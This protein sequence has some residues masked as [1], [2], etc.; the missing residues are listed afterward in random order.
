M[1]PWLWYSEHLRIPTYFGMLMLGMALSTI[2]LRRESQRSGIHPKHVFD[3]ALLALPMVLLGARLAHAIL[4]EPAVYATQP[5]LIVRLDR[6]GF[7]FYGGLITGALVVWLRARR[8][9]I[10]PWALADIF[11]MAVPFGLIFGRLGCLGGGCC[12]GKPASWPLG[13]EVPW[14]ILM[15]R[16]NQVPDELMGIPL[17]PTPLYAALAALALFIWLTTRRQKQSFTGEITLL[18]ATSYGLVRS[19]L[20]LFRADTSRGLYMDGLVSTSQIIGIGTA[21]I[22]VALL[23]YRSQHASRS[24]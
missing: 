18:F 16:R 14:S 7:V 20:E 9:Q 19:V 23:R 12:Y 13:V 11:T 17:H 4:V 5:W 6:G 3:T 10:D 2:V 22:G 24:V 1:H 21:L 8:L 15:V